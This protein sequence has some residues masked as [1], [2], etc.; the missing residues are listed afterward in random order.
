MRLLG[1]YYDER[2]WIVDF[3]SSHFIIKK[4][5]LMNAAGYP[6]TKDLKELMSSM[7][8]NCT[9]YERMYLQC[10]NTFGAALIDDPYRY[11]HRHCNVILKSLNACIHNNQWFHETKKY[12]PELF[13]HWK[14]KDWKGR[15]DVNHVDFDSF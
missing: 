2:E 12:M 10:I 15:G 3:T 13:N 5:E 11:E 9:K 7:Y 8:L 6:A 14:L 4:E 1:E